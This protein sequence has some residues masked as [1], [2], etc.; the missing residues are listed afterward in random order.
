MKIGQKI[1]VVDNGETYTTY[2][3]FNSLNICEEDFTHYDAPEE[4]SIGIVIGKSKHESSGE[5]IYG[6]EVNNKK[7]VIG[8][9]GIKK[10]K[11][12]NG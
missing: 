4:W 8:K 2:S 11:N 6:I 3:D 5:R 9:H 12:M 10:I 1:V 7:Y